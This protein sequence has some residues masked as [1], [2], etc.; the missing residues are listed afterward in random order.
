MISKI[1]IL[2]V[3]LT[4]NLRCKYCTNNSQRNFVNPALEVMKKEILCRIFSETKP[5]IDKN[6]K[7]T[8]IW[9]GGEST[10]AGLDFY[11][12]AIE[13][14]KDIFENQEIENGIQTN[15]ILIDDEWCK[16]FKKENF[17]PS[18]SLDGP[19]WLHNKLRV[20]SQNNGTYDRVFKSYQSMKSHDL[21]VGILGVITPAGFKF[22]TQFSGR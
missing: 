19:S 18:I 9:N 14:E 8:I 21:R 13:L 15:G 1:L 10:L 6:K 2:P 4:C 7:L 20:D 3:G 22:L 12:M 11:R 16:F 5:L 17:A